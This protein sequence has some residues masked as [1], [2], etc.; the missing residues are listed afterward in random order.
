MAH[1]LIT[2]LGRNWEIVPEI[3]GWTN[4]DLVDL[5]ANH[6][7]RDELETLRAEYGIEP[8]EILWIITT[9][10]LE[11]G[12]ALERLNAWRQAVGTCRV[13]FRVVRVSGIHDLSSLAECRRMR[14]AIHQVVL[15]GSAEAGA[16]GSLVLS[17]T[18]GRKTMSSDMQAA[19]AF[20]GCRA[21]VHI[22][23][24]DDKL[25][26]FRKLDVQDFC[27]PLPPALADAATP[28]V[29]GRHAPSPLLDYPDPREEPLSDCL[30]ES[31]RTD[32]APRSLWADHSLCVEDTRLL[33][34]L[35]N[36]LRAASNLAANH[37]SRIIQQ[38]TSANFLALYSLPP[39][40]IQRLKE[41][42]VGADPDPQ[43]QE[44][45]LDLLRRLPK[46]ELH[47]HL[48]GVLTV[49][50]IIQVADSVRERIEE[51]R[52]NL[53]PWLERRKSRLEN[54]DPDRLR[55]TIQWKELRRPV[56]GVPEPLPVAAFLLL[57][58]SCPHVLEKM[59]YGRYLKEENFVG[60]GFE[61]YERLGDLQGSALLQCEETLRATCRILGHKA[62]EHN[63]L[64]LEVRCSP[65]NYT[66]GGLSPARVLE[67]IADELA[68]S[69]PESTVLLLI[70]S[71]HRDLTALKE[72]VA[73]AQEILANAGAA[74]RMLVGFDLAGNEKAL[75]PA[76]VR[77][78]FLP[79][80]ERCLHATIHAGEIADAS[81]IW[82]AVY[83]L[84]AERIGHGLTLQGNPGLLERF[85][86][87]RIAVEMCPASNCQIVGFRDAHLP[88]TASRPVYPLSTYLRKGLRVTVNTDNPGISRTDFSREYQR[89]GRLSPGGLSLWDLLLLIR[90]GFKAAFTEAPRRHD[91]LRKA[92]NRILH[93]LER[94]F[95]L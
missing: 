24:R 42:V 75:E 81:S 47:C 21:L 92:E 95:E 54:E 29:V 31:L 8:V 78:A 38:E 18:G 7:N 10:D 4:P 77:E 15:R 2:T 3:L 87:R 13:R 46:A 11:I 22:V 12:K 45:E 61:D 51:Y 41:V 17:L 63:V 44:A 60:I 55:E 62:R 33:D 36:R 34:A 49:G 74:S 56:S 79:L 1:V 52:T 14:E 59:I 39:R 9:D 50:E 25:S 84:N 5:Y 76:K 35:E 72:N 86:D 91:L 71:R 88:G 43:R 89:A 67:I 26:H 73:L 28:V 20:F 69:G 57:F 64:H 19:A 82:Q 94:G 30:Q 48:G 93:V 6:P 53:Q 90:N 70:G 16:E 66:R 58:E 65:K 37:A 23:G 27:K 85:R 32:P 83:H 80:M 40:E 68:R